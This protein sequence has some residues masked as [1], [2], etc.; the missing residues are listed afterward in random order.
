M[1]VLESLFSLLPI[2]DK[3]YL[4]FILI[5]YK[6]YEYKTPK[7]VYHCVKKIFAFL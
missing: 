7:T 5:R 2:R 4:I 6:D 3:I 1:V